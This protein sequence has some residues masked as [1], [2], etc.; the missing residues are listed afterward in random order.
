MAVVR[1]S[2]DNPVGSAP[3]DAGAE[4]NRLLGA[5][6][7]I[8]VRDSAEALS[9]AGDD[10]AAQQAAFASRGRVIWGVSATY[11][12]LPRPWRTGGDH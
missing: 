9:G 2:C 6:A 5:F 1:S 7:R 3:A 11:K 12:S 8:Y 10:S 4:R